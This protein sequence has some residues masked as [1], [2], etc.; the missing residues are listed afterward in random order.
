MTGGR[1]TYVFPPDKRDNWKDMFGQAHPPPVPIANVVQQVP[2]DLQL[3]LTSGSGSVIIIQSET[4][5]IYGQIEKVFCY[6]SI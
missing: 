6:I 4:K 5:V 3:D 2:H 1:F